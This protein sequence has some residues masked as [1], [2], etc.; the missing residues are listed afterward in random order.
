M[1]RVSK[2]NE[3]YSATLL[4][5]RSQKWSEPLGK[6]MSFTGHILKYGGKCEVPFAGILGSA[7]TIGSKVLNPAPSLE[8]IVDSNRANQNK[9][10]EGSNELSQELGTIQNQVE[11]GFNEVFQDLETIQNLV[12]EG[13]I[14]VLQELKTI[15]IQIEGLQKTANKNLLITTEMNWEGGLKRV[16]AF[17]KNVYA[18]KSLPSIISYIDKAGAFFIEIQ[19]DA[20][21][22]FD[23][24]K[25]QE[26]MDFLT[27]EKGFEA[28]IN[29][30]NYAMALKSQFL[31]VLVLYHSFNNELD[32]VIF[33]NA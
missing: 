21:Q 8:D 32:E 25:L 14:E 2:T 31:L 29:F 13:F 5:V 12:E 19:T 27:E 7:L 16:K 30:Y 24:V 3:K 10:K 28:C 23:E 11:E 26:Y 9:I 33:L 22:H 17:C 6:A 15:Q 18:K 4:K 20:T 1:H